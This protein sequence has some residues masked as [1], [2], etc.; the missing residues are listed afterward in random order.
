VRAVE[1][2][3]GCDAILVVGDITHFGGVAQAGPLLDKLAESGLKVF[4]VAGNC[5]H[6]AL[7]TWTPSNPKIVNIH[8]KKTALGDFE[9]IG[10][11]GGNLSPFNTLIE[12]SEEEFARMLSSVNTSSERFI[13]VSHTPPYGGEADAARGRHLGSTAIRRFVEE[14][15]PIAVCCGH[16]HE[17]RSVS[18][19][20]GT[21]VVNAG[22]ARDGFC[23]ILNIGDKE[24]DAELHHL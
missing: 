4:F 7:L 12:F 19:I 3:S 5:D 24:V 21:K 15:R 8:L 17:A 22:P 10:L 6:P 16:I 23:A 20:G 2:S 9:M 1:K 11:G 13:L 18:S 14:K